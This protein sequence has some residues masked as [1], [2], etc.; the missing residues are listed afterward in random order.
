V[1]GKAANTTH[2]QL[3]AENESLRTR[4]DE[5]EETLR[6]IR[7]GEVDALI[8]SGVDG[9]QIFTLQQVEE[10]LRLSE[11]K[12][13]T[14]V[15]EV[16]DGFYA[17]DNAGVFTFANP[18]LARMFGVE[19]PQALLGRSFLD[20][21]SPDISVGVGEQHNSAM[22]SGHSPEVI[23]GQIMRPDGTHAFIEVKLSMMIKAGQTVG[24]QGVVRDIT[25]RKHAEQALRNSEIKLR[26]LFAAMLDVIVVYDADGR[27]LEIAPTN[28]ANLYCPPEE[29]LGKTVTEMLPPD[30]AHF[31]LDHIPQTLKTGQLTNADYSSNF[32]SQLRW[33][34]ALVSPL[35]SSS[36]IWVAHDITHRKSAEDRIRRQLEHLTAL[37]AID[38]IIS[39]FSDLKFS[40]SQILIHVTRELGIDAADILILNSNLPILEY[41]AEHGFHTNAVKNAHVRLGESYAGHAVIERKLIQIP[42]L[43]DEINDI[44][45]KAR[46][47]GENFVCYYSMPLITRGQVKGVLEVFHRT[48]LEPDEEWFEFLNSLAGQ[49]A[50]AIETATLFESLQTSNLDI[51]MA[52]DA[53]I[54]GWSHALDLRDQETEKHTQRV[55]D[56]T[57]NLARKFGLR[58]A[59]LKQVRWGALLHDIGKMG[60]PDGILLKKGPLTDEEWVAM[61]NHPNFAYEMLSPIHYLRL[62][63]DI[64]YCHH[65]KWDGSGYPQR[66]K[67]TQIPLV[68]RIFA[69]VDVWD[70]LI[71]DRPYRKAWTEEKTRL[72]IQSL[73]GTHFDALVVDSFMKYF[74]HI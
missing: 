37:S 20:F 69:V 73:S 36:V 70:A 8:I 60:V 29:M 21:V 5:A 32:G 59:E 35:S 25:E 66:L 71:S 57:V 54:E 33:F 51:T 22:Q 17:T 56:M 26:S 53:T 47:A 46:L 64:P 19:S 4:L 55:T 74:N 40:L 27:Y 39:S 44:F 16:N 2:K 24:T 65:E 50:I 41:G 58:D 72:H 30:Q 48:K 62:A 12:Y 23:N 6:A 13:R 49:V 42:D 63:L 45:L 10:A 28:P 38:R 61:K 68:A 1:P 52:Y 34:T 11:E 15:D 7:F 31:F 9:E 67:G 43:S 18:A 14:L 3:V